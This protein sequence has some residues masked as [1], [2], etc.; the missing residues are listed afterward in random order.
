MIALSHWNYVFVWSAHSTSD[1]AN[2][3]TSVQYLN[4]LGNMKSLHEY[5]V[6][7]CWNLLLKPLYSNWSLY[8]QF[9]PLSPFWPFFKYVGIVGNLHEIL[10]QTLSCF[11][12]KKKGYSKFPPLESGHSYNSI[13]WYSFKHSLCLKFKIFTTG[14]FKRNLVV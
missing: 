2:E 8:L 6:N 1:I 5:Y 7:L 10:S 14:F 9:Q 12:L 11:W 4:H 13:I 3:A